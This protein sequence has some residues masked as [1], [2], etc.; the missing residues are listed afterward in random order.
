MA[1]A[2]ALPS[3]QTPWS[4]GPLC[5]GCVTSV[6]QF[7]PLSNGDGVISWSHLAAGSCRVDTFNGHP[8]GC[9]LSVCRRLCLQV[10]RYWTGDCTECLSGGVLGAQPRAP[11]AQS[12]SCPWEVTL[13]RKPRERDAFCFFLR[14]W[15]WFLHKEVELAFLRWYWFPD[16]HPRQ[17]SDLSPCLLLTVSLRLT[18]VLPA[19]HLEPCS[20]G[21]LHTQQQ[22]ARPLGGQSS[23]LLSFLQLD[24]PSC[25]GCLAHRE[26]ILLRTLPCV[27]R[28]GRRGPTLPRS[29]RL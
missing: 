17:G 23:S 27:C 11:T 4:P 9:L 29:P 5:V 28:E 19:R 24:C 18:P 1:P 20:Q 10:G 14:P 21:A 7:P 22:P 16:N 15:L 3:T 6:P 13:D 12:W 25:W 8:L 2:S 26:N